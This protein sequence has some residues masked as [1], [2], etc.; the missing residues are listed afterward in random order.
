M[1]FIG[2][3]MMNASL[4]LTQMPAQLADLSRPRSHL[5]PVAIVGSVLLFYV[6]L[7]GVMDEMS[8]LLL[9][10]P[11]VFPAVMQLPLFGLAPEDKAL[12]F[13]V[14]L[15]T[16]GEHRADRATGGTERLRGRRCRRATCP[17][18]AP[19]AMCSCSSRPT[20]CG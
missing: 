17:S 7:G 12:W 11:V 20:R 15:L 16:V 13:G 6:V 9:T 18:H 3:D 8:M 2:A 10:L 1:I 4:A 19:T 5:S 14:L